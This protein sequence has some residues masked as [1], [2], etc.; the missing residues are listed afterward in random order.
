MENGN[1]TRPGKRVQKTMEKTM[2]IWDQE[3]CPTLMIIYK[4]C[5]L[6]GYLLHSHGIDGP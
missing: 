2:E 1:S 4:N 3:N 6:S 5:I